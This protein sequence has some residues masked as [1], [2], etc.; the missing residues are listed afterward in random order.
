MRCTRISQ[1]EQSLRCAPTVPLCV[2]VYPCPLR[3][4][5]VAVPGCDSELMC[6][7]CIIKQHWVLVY[8]PVL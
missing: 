8:S 3:R 7:V 1:L 2:N 5:R 6:I 4:A